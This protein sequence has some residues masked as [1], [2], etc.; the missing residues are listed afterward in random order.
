MILQVYPPS[1]ERLSYQLVSESD[2]H[3][4]VRILGTTFYY[5]TKKFFG[6][7]FF[8]PKNRPKK[9]FLWLA[10]DII[11]KNHLDEH[12]IPK[13]LHKIGVNMRKYL[14]LHVFVKTGDHVR[15]LNL[16]EHLF[17][18]IG[19]KTGDYVRM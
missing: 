11:I 6:Q 9:L 3:P 8:G 13:L 19:E 18:K 1:D 2:D 15:M 4:G 14:I 5:V 7:L 17:L 12:I 10:C 16:G